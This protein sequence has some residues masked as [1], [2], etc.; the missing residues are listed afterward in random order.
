MNPKDDSIISKDLHA[1]S[2]EDVHRAVDFATKQFEGGEWSKFSG[3]QRAKCLNKLADLIDGHVEEI[4]YFES[5]AS[6]RLPT[7]VT[8]EIPRVSAIFRCISLISQDSQTSLTVG[9]RLCRLGGQDQR[10]HVSSG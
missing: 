5:I 1:A 8:H 6:G 9:N 4:A 3:E 10:R 2:A 7:M